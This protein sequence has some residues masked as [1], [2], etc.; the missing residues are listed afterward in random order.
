MTNQGIYVGDDI[1]IFIDEP[2]EVTSIDRPYIV[3]SI[4]TEHTSANSSLQ[5]SLYSGSIPLQIG[6]KIY[7]F[8]YQMRVTRVLDALEVYSDAV[9]HIEDNSDLYDTR[10]ARKA[11]QVLRAAFARQLQ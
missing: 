9:R 11:I 10:L 8:Y 7:R 4:L 3:T 1:E 2:V 5:P 6:Q